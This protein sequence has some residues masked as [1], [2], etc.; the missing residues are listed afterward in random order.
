MNFTT[1]RSVP[2]EINDISHGFQELKGLVK[3]S[4]KGFELEFEVQD[5]ILGFFKSGITSL[6]IPFSDLESITYKSSWLGGK[7]IL[8]GKS[9]K[10]FEALPGAEVATCTLKVKRKHRK[11]AEQLISTARMK[12][13]EYKLNQLDS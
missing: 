1:N 4:E 7:V 8:E 12:F 9:M 3:L 10:V 5:S 13:S 6:T 11:E 2:F